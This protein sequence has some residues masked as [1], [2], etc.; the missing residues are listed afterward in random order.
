MPDRRN[1]RGAAG[2]KDAIHRDGGQAA[3]VEQVVQGAAHAIEV[4]FDP[5]FKLRARN[6]LMEGNGVGVEAEL[7]LVGGGEL[8][9]QVLDTAVKLVAEVLLDDGTQG[10]DLF[11]FERTFFRGA[12]HLAHAVGA[13]ERKGVP[14]L[15]PGIDPGRERRQYLAERLCSGL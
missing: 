10:G 4:G 2:E 15:K 1:K 11:R 13:Q 9:L 8:L 6:V 14:A 5:R 3:A 7:R 12:Q